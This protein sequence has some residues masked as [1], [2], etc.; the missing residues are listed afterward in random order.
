MIVPPGHGTRYN[1]IEYGVHGATCRSERHQHQT[2][3]DH[4]ISQQPPCPI[5]LPA[6][7]LGPNYPTPPH[8]FLFGAGGCRPGRRAA[9]RTSGG[10]DFTT[11]L[12]PILGRPE[13]RRPFVTLCV[14]VRLVL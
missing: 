4:H 2:H 8:C 6:A 10:I 3:V 11:R 5:V 1:S 9:S 14:D 7:F 12:V 13:Q